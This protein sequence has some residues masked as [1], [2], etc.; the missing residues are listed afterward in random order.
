M[1]I[2]SNNYNIFC[3]NNNNNNKY[4]IKY[5]ITYKESYKKLDHFQS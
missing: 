5:T 4:V 3:Y 1:L 2:N